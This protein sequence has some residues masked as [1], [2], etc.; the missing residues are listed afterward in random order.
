V[1]EGYTLV[2][3]RLT[4]RNDALGLSL[5]GAVTNLFDKYYLT[6]ITDQR[7]SFGFNSANVG[8][9]REWS[10]TLRKEF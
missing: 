10:L 3:A 5:A 8:R 4:W 2:N 6:T 9:P 1:Q 7:E